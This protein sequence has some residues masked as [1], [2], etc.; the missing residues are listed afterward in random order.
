MVSRRILL[1]LSLA[2]AGSALADDP[3]QKPRQPIGDCPKG[4]FHEYGSWSSWNSITIR[5]NECSWFRSKY[6]EKCGGRKSQI[7]YRGCD[8]PPDCE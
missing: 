7:T 6:C 1:L 4:G 2:W 8:D 5:N 3:P